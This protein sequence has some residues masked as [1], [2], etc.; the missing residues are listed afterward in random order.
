MNNAQESSGK[1]FQTIA[2]VDAKHVHSWIVLLSQA[3]IMIFKQ[4]IGK[5]IFTNAFVVY[6]SLVFT[7][8]SQI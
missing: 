3:A 1:L 5:N 6:Y 2:F 4:C 7:L 8:V